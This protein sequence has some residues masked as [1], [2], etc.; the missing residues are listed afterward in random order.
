VRARELAIVQ[1]HAPTEAHQH[2]LA[3]F[4]DVGVDD[5]GCRRARALTTRA[6]LGRDRLGAHAQQLIDAQPG[7][8][9]TVGIERVQVRAAIARARAPKQHATIARDRKGL[10]LAQAKA[11]RGRTGLEKCLIDRG[12]WSRRRY[13][14]GRLCS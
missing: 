9:L 6:L 8:T 7:V 4:G 10:R 14:G 2:T 1:E 5:A 11:E 12:P 13:P 3:V